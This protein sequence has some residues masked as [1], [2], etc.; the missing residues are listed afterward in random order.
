MR[1]AAHA[2]LRPIR[3]L[4]EVEYLVDASLGHAAVEV[5]EQAQVAAAREVRIEARPL[6]E[7][8]DTVERPGAVD[9]RVA[10]E[11][12]R[13]PGRRAD[14]PE[15]HPQRRG[16]PR[17]VRPEIAEDVAALDGQL[18]VIDRGDLAVA[19][20]EPADLDRRGVAHLSSR[21]ADSAAAVGTEPARTKETPPRSHP[22]IVPS[23]VASS[24]AVTPSSDTDG[25]ELE[26]AAALVGRIRV[27]LDDDDRAEPLAVHD[28]H[29]AG[30]RRPRRGAR[31]AAADRQVCR[32]RR[33]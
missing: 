14:Q 21:A 6:D 1:V 11:E 31:P 23:W 7:A 22:T 16:L 4:D 33:P 19:L 2:V 10:A 13:E 18:D 32:A 15:Q 20:D 5:A 29:R 27:P 17:A 28:E 25:S 30:V 12:E 9:L 8:G 26:H 3:E 24:C